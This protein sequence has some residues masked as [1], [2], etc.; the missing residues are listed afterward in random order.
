MR[1]LALCAGVAALKINQE[2]ITDCWIK[3]AKY[4]GP[5]RQTAA[6]IWCDDGTKCEGEG[7]AD[8]VCDTTQGKAQKCN[9]PECPE[10]EPAPDAWE[11]PKNLAKDAKGAP[12]KMEKSDDKPY[13]VMREGFVCQ[14][15]TDTTKSDG[16]L[17]EDL[18]ME[19]LREEAY[20]QNMKQENIL[21]IA[22]PKSGQS[23]A[24]KCGEACDKIGGAKYMSFNEAAE[25]P[26]P[27]C[28]C[29]LQCVIDETKPKMPGA[30]AYK[31]TWVQ[32]GE[33]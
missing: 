22:T 1:V 25:A 26:I 24:D 9:I 14:I 16:R 21:A 29:F 7:G 31:R 18:D 32:T 20:K 19:K 30:A 27:K 5:T 8:I 33:K 13:E 17:N 12:C 3:G 6:G 23:D 15:V 4:T 11:R 2:K 28:A 10:Q